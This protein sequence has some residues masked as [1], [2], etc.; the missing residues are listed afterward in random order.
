MADRD[1]IYDRTAGRC[2]VCCKQLS[3]CNYGKHGQRGAWEIEHSVA[4]ARG[5]SDHGNNLYPACIGCNRA[6][7]TVTSRTARAR[8]GRTRAPLSLKRQGEVRARRA[9]GGG[10]LGA[11]AAGLVGAPILVPMG[12][13]A[14]V[15]YALDPDG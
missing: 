6:K 2:H 8:N 13:A 4:R 5:G 10:V 7:G 3:R 1:R 9:V 11:M 12:L 15:G 14:L